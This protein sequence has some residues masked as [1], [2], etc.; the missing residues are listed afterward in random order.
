MTAVPMPPVCNRLLEDLPS[1]LRSAVLAA[2]EQV[3]LPF[4]RVLYEQDRTFSHVYFPLTTVISM[5]TTVSEHPPLGIV[6]IG[7]EGMLGATLML[8]VKAAPLRAVVQGPGTA[9]RMDAARFPGLLRDNPSLDRILSRY[10]YVLLE[11]LSQTAACVRFHEVETRLVRWLLLTHDRAHADHFHLTHQFLADM[12]GVQRSAITIAAGV[13]QQKNLISYS[14]GEITIVNRA[15]L[16][17]ICC[18]CYGV[19]VA[20]YQRLIA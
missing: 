16:E 10:L 17:A 4:G 3:N 1:R 8:G 20:D 9:L 11:Q 14:R 18:E 2:C 13:L 7:N 5:V 6:L 12:L 19:V 15:G